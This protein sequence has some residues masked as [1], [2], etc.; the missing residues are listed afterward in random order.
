[1]NNIVRNNEIAY[2]RDWAYYSYRGNGDS[3]IGNDFIGNRHGIKIESQARDIL[4]EDNTIQSVPDYDTY[5]GIR[6]DLV[7]D[8]EISGNLID[9]VNTALYAGKGGNSLIYNN[10]RL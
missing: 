1:M 4:I 8:Y 2:N 6:L 10:D 3:L 5:Y 9:D 7:Y